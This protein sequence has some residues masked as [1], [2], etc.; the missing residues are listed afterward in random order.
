MATT[1][2]KLV[3]EWG[4]EVDDSQLKQMDATARKARAQF[5]KLGAAAVGAFAA[6]IVP[7]AKLQAAIKDTLTLSEETGQAFENLERDM[8][9]SALRMSW[10]RSRTSMLSWPWA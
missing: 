8:T 3:T 5:M 2:R 4:F 9:N 6:V 7:A 10:K 1:L